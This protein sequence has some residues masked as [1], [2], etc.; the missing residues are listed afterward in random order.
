MIKNKFRATMTKT[1]IGHYLMDIQRQPAKLF[2]E[3]D[4]GLR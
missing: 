3:K 1:L 2:R 4:R